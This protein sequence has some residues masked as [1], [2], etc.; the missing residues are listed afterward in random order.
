MTPWGEFFYCETTASELDRGHGIFG[1]SI[2]EARSYTIQVHL[3]APD[4][5]RCLVL[6]TLG[7]RAEAAMVIAYVITRESAVT[8]I[9][10]VVTG[11]GAAMRILSAYHAGYPQVTGVL[12]WAARYA[13]SEEGLR[14][15]QD[16]LC[17]P[18]DEEVLRTVLDSAALLGKEGI[19][20]LDQMIRGEYAKF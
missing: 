14:I 8:V 4:P 12:A 17:E 10:P 7:W 13:P 9:E 11:E 3:V 19:P 16:I 15:L 1:A 2:G 20:I 18:Q 5:R 6:G